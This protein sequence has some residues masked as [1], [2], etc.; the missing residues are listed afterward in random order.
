MAAL[1]MKEAEM[2][3]MGWVLVMEG[4]EKGDLEGEQV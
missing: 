3:A 1:F 2:R 4:R